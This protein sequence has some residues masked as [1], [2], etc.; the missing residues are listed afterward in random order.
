MAAS[1]D[2]GGH[3][4]VRSGGGL[5]D[6]GT[7]I[8]SCHPLACHTHTHTYVRKQVRCSKKSSN[9]YTSR[10]AIVR[11][12]QSHHWRGALGLPVHSPRGPQPMWG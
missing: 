1:Q 3:V 10:E 11:T 9:R 7:E 5:G 2:R 12:G 6:V 4:V 8:V